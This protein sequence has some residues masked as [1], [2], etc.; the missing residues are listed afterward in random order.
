MILLL[1]DCVDLLEDEDPPE[2]G[3]AADGYLRGRD[4][5]H[6]PEDP[7]PPHDR[8][9]GDAA[10]HRVGHRARPRPRPRP[11]RQ[12]PRHAQEAR[13]LLHPHLQRE[14][15]LLTFGFL[16]LWIWTFGL[17]FVES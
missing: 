6:R 4:A 10:P 2:D 14:F 12:A 9:H 1:L 17:N 8:D 7:R 13:E 16:I 5:G 11:R 15:G 3:G